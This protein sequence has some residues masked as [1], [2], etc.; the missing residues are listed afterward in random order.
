MTWRFRLAAVSLVLV[1]IAFVQA[2]GRMV[3]DTKLDLVVDPAGFLSRA[4][5]MWDPVGA[6]GQ[7]QNQAYGY[8]FPMGPFFLL[9]NL[10][11]VEPWVIQRLWWSLLLVTAFLGMVKLSGALGIGAPWARIVAGLAYALSPRMLTVLGPSSI[12]VWPM[13]LALWV[14]VPLVIG[15]RRH[16]P[17]WMAALSALAVAC[18]GGVNAVAT[19]AVIPLGALW[20]LLQPAS[21]RRRSM[22]IWWPVFVLLGTL[23]WLVPLLMLGT[24]SP[25]FLDYI[26]SAS[27]TTFAATLFD[28]LRGTTNW[29]P[30]VD[31]NSVAGNDLL[32]SIGLIVNGAVVVALGIVGIARRG[33]PQRRFLLGGLLMGL[34]LVTLGHTGAVHGWGAD[35]IQQA[36]DGVLA[37]LR[38]THKFDLVV[39]IPLV[40]GFAHAISSLGSALRESDSDRLLRRGIA[41]LGVSALLGA[42]VPAWTGAIASRGAYESVPGYWQ[43]T[44]DWLAQ[45]DS[46]QRSL[47]VPAA[48]F[49]DYLWG[50]T[51]DDVIQPLAEAPWATRNAIPLAPGGNILTLDAI[52]RR[53]ASGEGSDGL[54]DYLERSGIRYLVVRNDLAPSS[55]HT[56]PERIYATLAKTPGVTSVAQFGPGVGSPPV[57]T[58]EDGEEVLIKGGWQAYRPAVEIFAVGSSGRGPA[59]VQDLDDTPVVAGGPDSLL[60]L[61]EL[62]LAP[63]AAILADDVADRKERPRHVVLTDGARRREAAFGRADQNRSGSIADDESYSLDRP[64]HDYRVSPTTDFLSSPQ[65]IGTAGIEASSSQSQAGSPGPAVPGAQPWSAFDGDP[66]THWKAGGADTGTSWIE[67]QLGGP[68]D[69]D[70]IVI[71][72]APTMERSRALT[73]TTD[74]GSVDAVAQPGLPVTVDLPPGATDSIRISAAASAFDPITITEV[75]VPGLDLSRPLV[76]PELPSSWGA[77]DDIVM[78]VDQTY[79]SGCL[80]VEGTTRCVASQEQWGEDGRTLDRE[81]T[82]STSATY[83]PALTV[84]PIGG[85]ALDAAAQAGRLAAVGASSYLVEDPRNSAVRSID[86]DPATGWIAADDD[87]DPTLTLAWV[88]ERRIRGLTVGTDDDLGASPPTSA[89]LRFDD[90]SVREVELDEGVA[91]FAPVVASSVEVHFD[92][93]ETR[94]GVDAFGVTSPLPVGVSEIDLR[95]PRRLF[96]QVPSSASVRSRCGVGPAVEIDG[97]RYRTR[98]TTSEQSTLAGESAP[99]QICGL[100]EVALDEGT[101]RIEVIGN[102]VYRPQS[103]VLASPE[104]GSAAEPTVAATPRWGK[105]E[106]TVSLDGGSATG[107]RL[108]TVAENV[109]EGWRDVAGARRVQVDGW[110][111]GYVVPASAD[112]LRLE[113]APAARYRSALLVGALAFVA[114]LGL[115]MLRRRRLRVPAE[116][117]R[118]FRGS[119]VVLGLAFVT[120]GLLAGT[121]GLALAVAGWALGLL[122]RRFSADAVAW[123]AAVPVLVAAGAYAVLPWGSDDGWAGD[124]VWPQLVL[125]VSLGL[126]SASVVGGVRLR[127]TL[128]R[129]IDGSSTTR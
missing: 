120:A 97:R 60:A 58:G 44:A 52:E 108:V 59:S 79:R 74:Q 62:G 80:D 109:N 39:R 22:M 33:T 45:H 124:L 107:D 6:F 28:A 113:F 47:L 122:V 85:A 86:G 4:L 15:M 72:L 101:H 30:Y 87:P 46:G 118:E 16:D 2:P 55:E 71:T 11:E 121:A 38:N 66:R 73:V 115:T 70:E 112:E 114:L 1:A 83:T 67:V 89:T 20:L 84:V 61:D 54:A 119:A 42:T 64:V 10:A 100:P 98:V 37:P 34:L 29:V 48:S 81:L 9:G 116:E 93:V 12:E 17:R 43:E 25:P 14:L 90:G 40:L 103:L 96:P 102:D 117:E 7:V 128:R 51:A 125:A 94:E 77:P 68:T 105:T 76:M 32:R 106:R 49:G 78:T 88:G 82:M 50:R 36:L 129:R 23:W 99:A 75:E 18:V 35:S 123:L 21:P 56:D 57:L 19:F 63:G 5:T 127:P 95:G 8:L 92:S 69:V 41:V 104:S 31:G 126:L 3:A 24:Y 26:E 65:M 91:R 110:Q 27:T 111:Q 13:A 53:L